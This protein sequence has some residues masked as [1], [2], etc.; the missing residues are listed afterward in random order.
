MPPKQNPTTASFCT[1]SSALTRARKDSTIA[2]VSERANQTVHLSAEVSSDGYMVEEGRQT[3][4]SMPEQ[5]RPSRY[6]KLDRVPP[7]PPEDLPEL[8]APTPI[9]RSDGLNA[10]FRQKPGDKP[11]RLFLLLIRLLRLPQVPSQVSPTKTTSRSKGEKDEPEQKAAWGRSRR[12]RGSTLGS[13]R[14]RTG[15]REVW[16]S[17]IR[18]EAQTRPCRADGDRQSLQINK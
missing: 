5:P 4:I 12:C 9:Y 17:D 13:P 8:S 14:P 1:S 18:L 2:S 16:G 3:C 7:T 10:Q 15:R 6:S 11:F